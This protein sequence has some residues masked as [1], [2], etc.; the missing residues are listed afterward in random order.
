[1]PKQLT[2]C[3]PHQ[4]NRVLLGMKKRG[5]GVGRWNGFGGKLEQGETI[6]Q[7]AVREAREECGIEIS[8]MEKLGVV[9]FS[10][11]SKND[12]EDLEVHVFKVR[13]FEGEPVETEEMKPAW[14][15]LDEIPFTSMWQDDPHWFPYF[16][17]DRK[18][19]AKFSF[20][21]DD[22]VIDFEVKVI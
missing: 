4:E 6:E 10:W 16:L 12:Q 5:F 7:A 22:R 21:T 8:D 20:D 1:M 15:G 17:K 19:E 9:Q 3:I 14:F 13:E 2:L 11:P 18:F